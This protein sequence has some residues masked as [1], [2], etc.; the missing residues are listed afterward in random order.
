VEAARAITLTFGAK[1]PS[2]AIAFE[3]KDCDARKLHLNTPKGIQ[4]SG[5]Y[6]TIIFLLALHCYKT[7]HQAKCFL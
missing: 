4:C 7:Y 6:Q 1:N 3:N 5:Q 2:Y